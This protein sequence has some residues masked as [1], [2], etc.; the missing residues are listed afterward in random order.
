[1]HKRRRLRK[2][3]NNPKPSFIRKEISTNQTDKPILPKS[4]CPFQKQNMAGQIIKRGDSFLVRIFIGRDSKGKRKYYNKT[5]RGSKKD[6]QKY[7]TAKLREMDLGVFVEPASIGLNDFLNNWLDENAKFKLRERT[8][9]NYKSLL[10]RHIRP[11]LGLK[12][13][14]DIQAYEIQKVYNGMK[15]DGFSPKTIR[16][17]HNVLS[18]ALK[19]AVKLQM[20]SNNPCDVCELPRQEKPEMKYFS[21]EETARFLKFAQNDK[22]YSVFLI[23]IETGMRP[24]EYLGLQ[25]KDI[26]FNNKTASVRRAVVVRK[27]GGFDFTEPKTK[28]S[29]RSIPISNS[30]ID[31]LKKHRKSQLEERIKNAK[32]YENFDLVFASEIGTPLL[33]QNLTRRHFKPIRD[34]AG[35]PKIRLYDLRHTTATL[36]LSAGENP[37]VVSE[38]LGHASIV[39]TLDTYSHVLPTMQET[40]TNKIEKLMLGK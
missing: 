2:A 34:A 36:L 5:I 8:L 18:S 40:A 6:A 27:G 10:N 3:T 14:C 12:R 19:Q 20:L 16:H 33:H 31:A 9:E 13:L 29:R 21:P 24:E 15:K 37:K 28:K 1:M 26:N 11:K 38:R 35:L 4:V 22:Y 25:W 39:L 32:R 17:A 23:A 7:L 30:I